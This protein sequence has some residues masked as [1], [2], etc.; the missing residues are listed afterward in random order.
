MLSITRRW[1]YRSSK[2]SFINLSHFK[3]LV[4]TTSKIWKQHS[5]KIIPQLF[6]QNVGIAISRGVH[7]H[8]DFGQ[9]VLSTTI[10]DAG[11]GRGS[12]KIFSYTWSVSADRSK[13]SSLVKAL[14][15][16]IG[17]VD[18][19]ESLEMLS[20]PVSHASCSQFEQYERC[21]AYDASPSNKV[22]PMSII[23]DEHAIV[24]PVPN[25][26]TA[27]IREEL[28]SL[29]APV[30]QWWRRERQSVRKDLQNCIIN[31]RI[32]ETHPTERFL[33]MEV[34]KMSMISDVSLFRSVHKIFISNIDG[35]FKSSVVE[36]TDEFENLR[37]GTDKSLRSSAVLFLK[38]NIGWI[39][40]AGNLI[41]G[42]HPK[43][44]SLIDN[45]K[46]KKPPCV[47]SQ[48]FIS[49][50]TSSAPGPQA[51]PKDGDT[52][53][54]E[55]SGGKAVAVSSPDDTDKAERATTRATQEASDENSLCSLL[56]HEVWKW[57]RLQRYLADHIQWR[58]QACGDFDHENS[59]KPLLVYVFSETS[60]SS[61]SIEVFRKEPD[62]FEQPM[63]L[64][65]LHHTLPTSGC[66]YVNYE[67]LPQ[68][69]FKPHQLRQRKKT[70]LTVFSCGLKK[71]I[72]FV[73]KAGVLRKSKRPS[74]NQLLYDL[75]V[76]INLY[77]SAGTEAEETHEEAQ[78]M[79]MSDQIENVMR[80]AGDLY[81]VSTMLNEEISIALSQTDGN[82]ACD[83]VNPNW[84]NEPN[85]VLE[86]RKN[87][88]INIDAANRAISISQLKV[89][90]RNQKNKPHTL[91]NLCQRWKGELEIEYPLMNR[92]SVLRGG[93][94]DLAIPPSGSSK[95]KSPVAKEKTPTKP[96][97]PAI[98]P[99]IRYIQSDDKRHDDDDGFSIFPF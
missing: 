6:A 32:I 65:K 14:K 16:Y 22:E 8:R 1:N 26:D 57:Y 20:S 50:E 24:S 89:R 72:G 30:W 48:P 93:I 7:H 49:R 42:K 66:S 38:N 35:S 58:M 25:P 70:L 76:P 77:F 19:H 43:L 15:N 39:D 71:H 90:L 67:P 5:D 46:G 41:E 51:V 55:N 33:R 75:K 45:V 80:L 12:R 94:H 63:T 23:L 83:Q 36:S 17:S 84:R 88:Q 69:V 62:W 47:D 21:F 54:V 4:L 18:Q 81:A 82:P 97:G 44:G 28:L 95:T 53:L 2:N 61:I 79:S 64:Y 34:W 86:T 13:F 98:S 91:A 29:A 92:E 68:T 73:D 37:P 52:K 56:Q 3:G 59:R 85:P 87:G 40:R 99:K 31:I 78:K 10:Y 74:I 60:D 96:Q 27:V 11:V 9:D